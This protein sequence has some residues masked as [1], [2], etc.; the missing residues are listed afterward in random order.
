M[1]NQ[2][3][4]QGRTIGLH[5]MTTIVCSELQSILV[6]FWA[7]VVGYPLHVQHKQTK[8]AV[9][10]DNLKLFIVLNLLLVGASFT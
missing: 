2:K 3:T 8:Q 10:S 9:V 1:D 5:Y 6:K 4:E 7:V